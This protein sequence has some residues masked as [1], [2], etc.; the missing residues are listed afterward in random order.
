LAW[1][2]SSARV[3][4]TSGIPWPYGVMFPIPARFRHSSRIDLEAAELHDQVATLGMQGMMAN[5]VLVTGSRD[6]G[7]NI[8]S[9]FNNL[10]ESSACIRGSGSNQAQATADRDIAPQSK[11][12][13]T[14]VMAGPS[15]PHQRRALTPAGVRARPVPR[16]D[17]SAELIGS[18]Q[19]RAPPPQALE[20]PQGG[21]PAPRDLFGCNCERW[22]LYRT[23]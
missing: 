20:Y 7:S 2:N 6:G 23:S 9:T 14:S 8:E 5:N 21:H 15:N 18:L 13:G 3:Y 17:G 19:P 10:T 12:R 16:S 4:D 1:S 11:S 22:P